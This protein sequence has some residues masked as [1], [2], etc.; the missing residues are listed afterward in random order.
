MNDIIESL[1]AKTE[2]LSIENVGL[3]LLIKALVSSH[4]DPDRLI[5]C[6]DAE[7]DIFAG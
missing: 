4:N 6:I 7:E 1:G 5:E 3:K 2:R